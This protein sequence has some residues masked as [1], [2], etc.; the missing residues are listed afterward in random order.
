MHN[1]PEEN[2]TVVDP[3]N[4]D[5]NEYQVPRED[6]DG[7]LHIY[8]SKNPNKT[9]LRK[10]ELAIHNLMYASDTPENPQQALF[11]RETYANPHESNASRGAKST[12]F[13]QLFLHTSASR[14]IT[15]ATFTAPLP[16]AAETIFSYSVDME[17]AFALAG[18]FWED[19]ADDF[20]PLIALAAATNRLDTGTYTAATAPDVSS[21]GKVFINTAPKPA[22]ADEPHVSTEQ[23]TNGKE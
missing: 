16:V 10:Q 1:H 19:A 11:A 18:R 15:G 6:N 20:A 3:N 8:S 2:I 5:W 7:L 22:P 12:T 17:A 14:L 23:E 13:C 4:N 21:T 9:S